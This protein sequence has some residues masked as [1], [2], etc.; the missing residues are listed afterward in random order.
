MI[1]TEDA[2]KDGQAYPF[3]QQ[4]LRE[5]LEWL[6][7]RSDPRRATIVTD[8]GWDVVLL[9]QVLNEKNRP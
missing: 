8:K 7:A 5:V 6:E 2:L 3:A 9:A 4:M 1:M